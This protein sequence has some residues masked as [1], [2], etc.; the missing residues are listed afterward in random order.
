MKRNGDAMMRASALA[1]FALLSVTASAQPLPPPA[2]GAG[3]AAALGVP[4]VA[5]TAGPASLT[6]TTSETNMAVLRIPANT[7]GKNGAFEVV[8]V[9]SFPNNANTKTML[10]RYSP[11]SGA[12]TGGALGSA[13]SATTTASAQTLWIIRNNNS[14]ANQTN[15]AVAGV[16]P[17]G[18]AAPGVATNLAVDTTADSYLNINGQLAVATDTLILQHAYLVVYPHQ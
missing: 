13:T 16:T 1:V 10:V 18:T 2:S 12:V 8:A 15:W 14:T 3:A 17:F 11:V 6:G 5:T 9:W 7:I 4:Y